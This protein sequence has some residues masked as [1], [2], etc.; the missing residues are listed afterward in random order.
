MS[1]LKKGLWTGGNSLAK[2]LRTKAGLCHLVKKLLMSSDPA[3]TVDHKPGSGKSV[4]RGLLRTGIQLWSWC[5]SRE[6]TGHSKNIG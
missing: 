3:G 1:R 5:K 4:R 2:S 6:C